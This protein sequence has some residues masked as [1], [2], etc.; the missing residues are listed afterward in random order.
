MSDTASVAN[1]PPNRPAM[2]VPEDRRS[3]FIA[4]LFG[5]RHFF[6][7]EQNLFSLMEE[8]SP[9]DYRGGFW[10]FYTL[11]DQ[12]LYLAPTG[13][14]RYQIGCEGNGYE[15]EVS[16]DAAG[17]IATLF[18]FSHM[19]FRYRSEILTEGYARLYDY[20]SVHAEAGEIF[21]AID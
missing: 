17:I 9:V 5:Q 1:L 14:H 4:L 13:R 11:D 20:A 21:R 10:N 8:L 2:L 3:G 16:A 18:T 6:V 19:S 7:A 15:G 12:P